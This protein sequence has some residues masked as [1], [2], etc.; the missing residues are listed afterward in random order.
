[1]KPKNTIRNVKYFI[2]RVVAGKYDWDSRDVSISDIKHDPDFNQITATVRYDR[3]EFG[4]DSH[5]ITMSVEFLP[6]KTNCEE[7]MKTKITT[8]ASDIV[9]S[10]EKLRKVEQEA[11]D[12]WIDEVIIAKFLSTCRDY[13]TEE[14]TNVDFDH[15]AIIK[16]LNSRGFSVRQLP[17]FRNEMYLEVTIPPQGEQ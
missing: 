7:T 3:R 12:K 13:V 8:T 14:I 9:A 16:E 17:N 10:M 5:T 2:E 4:G 11:I 1:M 6:Q 15:K